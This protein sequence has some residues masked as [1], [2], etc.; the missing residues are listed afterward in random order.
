MPSYTE[1]DTDLMIL[2]VIKGGIIPNVIPNNQLRKFMA[3][4]DNEDS[5]LTSEKT[6]HAFFMVCAFDAL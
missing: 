6:S 1:N 5:G 2:T 3:G 4:S